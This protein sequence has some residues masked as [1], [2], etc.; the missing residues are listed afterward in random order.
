MP[1]DECPIPLLEIPAID[2]VRLAAAQVARKTRGE[3]TGLASGQGTDPTVHG[4]TPAVG[5]GARGHSNGPRVHNE[6]IIPIALNPM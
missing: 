3:A 2:G 4:A 6:T 1:P 5:P